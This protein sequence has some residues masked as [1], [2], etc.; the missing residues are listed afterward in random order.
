MRGPHTLSLA[1]KDGGKRIRSETAKKG[2]SGD[3]SMKS[4]EVSRGYRWS[5]KAV[6]RP[7]ACSSDGGTCGGHRNGCWL[8]KCSVSLRS[9]LEILLPLG[10][11]SAHWVLSALDS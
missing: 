8:W 5:S 10:K 3:R 1:N 4:W 7:R 2:M 9:P 11:P 6:R